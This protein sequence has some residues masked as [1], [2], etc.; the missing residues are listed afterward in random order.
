MVEDDV[1]FQQAKGTLEKAHWYYRLSPSPQ[2]WQEFHQALKHYIQALEE[3]ETQKA[4][5][6]HE[7][8][9]SLGKKPKRNC[10]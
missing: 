4:L 7:R 5:R 2:T 10:S 8:L 9:Q 3:K 6:Y 1:F